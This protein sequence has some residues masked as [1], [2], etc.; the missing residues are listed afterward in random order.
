M[1]NEKNKQNLDVED[2]DKVSGGCQK[3]T[4]N[5]VRSKS[6]LRIDKLACNCVRLPG[7]SGAGLC[8]RCKQRYGIPLSHDDL[9]VITSS[10][11]QFAKRQ[12]EDDAKLR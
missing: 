10:W 1:D 11:D 6:M 4:T 3:F 5:D 9:K 12:L 8:T 7:E 2:L